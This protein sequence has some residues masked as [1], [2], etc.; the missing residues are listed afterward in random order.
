MGRVVGAFGW[1]FGIDEEKI[2]KSEC[3]I[4]HQVPLKEGGN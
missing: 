4:P 1:Y 2:K 3:E